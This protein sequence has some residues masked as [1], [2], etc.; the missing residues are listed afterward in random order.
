MATLMGQTALTLASGSPRRRELLLSLGFVFDVRSADL[1]E[2]VEPAELPERYV[3]RLS[4]A[5]AEAVRGARGSAPRSVVLAADTTV[6]LGGRIL[7]KPSDPEEARSMLRALSGQSHRVLTGVTVLPWQG[8]PCTEV[9]ETAVTFTN[10]SETQI[11]WYVATEEPLDK[12]GAYA[13]QGRGGAFVRRISGSYS[14]VVG[15][16]LSETVALLERAQ[17]SAPW[18]SP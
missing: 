9:V 2:A 15:L 10:L 17:V 16:P 3:A 6:V 8:E 14:N 1:D 12:A 13:I 18:A 5:K 4:C 11:A 7:G